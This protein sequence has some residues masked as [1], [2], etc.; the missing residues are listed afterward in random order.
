MAYAV[1]PALLPD[2][3]KVYDCYFAAFQADPS[4]RRLLDILFPRGVTSPSFRRAQAEAT[5]SY[6]RGAD[7][8]Y[9]FKCVEAQTGAIVGMALCDIF[10]RRQDV[11]PPPEG[12]A[13]RGGDS[14]DGE[15]PGIP[16]L[17]GE[18]KARAERVVKPLWE[19]REKLWGGKRYIY[20]HVFA[21]HPDHQGRG[22]GTALVQHIVD[23]GAATGLPI[24]LESAP[25]S[26]RL[27]EKLGF[28]RMRESVVHKAEALGAEEDV[29]VPL[30][31]RWPSRK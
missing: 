17:E 29:T 24:Y 1:L 23:V 21:V 3:E 7:A 28:Q 11:T 8:Q 16:W 6:W 26:T 22:A 15:W 30:M 20:V 9:T 5:A 10:V 27:Y 13:Q 19:M 14:S 4:G 18:E 2:I 31:V 12:A 25:T